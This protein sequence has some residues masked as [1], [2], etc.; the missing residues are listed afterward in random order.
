[1]SKHPLEEKL[2]L[3]FSDPNLL[4]KAL[5]HTS[6]SHENGGEHNERLEFLGDAV[7][8]M[9][10]TL[11]LMAHF[12][13][14]REGELSR[15]RARLVNTEVLAEVG[16][17]LNVGEHLHLGRGEE[18]H[19]GRE[20]VSIL[21]NA[22]EAILG[23]VYL[24]AGFAVC[25]RVVSDWMTPRIERLDKPEERINAWK[26]DRSLLQEHLQATQGRPP[27]YRVE[28][29]DGPAHRPVFTAEVWLGTKIVGQ[30]Q[31]QT[32]REASRA[33]A[34]AALLHFGVLP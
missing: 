15:L 29:T 28:Q 7:L 14:A 1:M 4:Q 3:V 11:L 16:V 17:H 31:G 5:T 24:D 23:A 22:V 26:D 34:K 30:G 6:W 8:E 12:S 20:R 33:A 13:S 9:C 18:T 10:T 2:G 21:E 32:K 27:I 25:Q 19:G